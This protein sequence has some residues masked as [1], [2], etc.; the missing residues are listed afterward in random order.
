VRIV[1]LL[2]VIVSMITYLTVRQS[3][4]RGMMPMATPDNPMGQSQ[5]Y[6]VHHAVLR[7][8]RAVLAIRSSCTG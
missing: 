4:K 5:K 2:T 8:V 6:G 1:I 7:A 3:M